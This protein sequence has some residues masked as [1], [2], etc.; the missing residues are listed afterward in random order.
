MLDAALTSKL[1][2]MYIETVSIRGAEKLKGLELKSAKPT[3]LCIIAKQPTDRVTCQNGANGS[4]HVMPPTTNG[5]GE[6]MGT[7]IK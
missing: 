3:S 4:W 5:A 2:P 6:M 1:R 7:R